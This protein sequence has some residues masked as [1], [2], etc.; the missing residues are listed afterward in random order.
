[1]RVLVTG[2]AGVIGSAVAAALSEAATRPTEPTPLDRPVPLGWFAMVVVVGTAILVGT[3]GHRLS[4]RPG[5]A[6]GGGDGQG[7][8]RR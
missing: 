5:V 4:T 1:M 8:G 7:H 3:I 2:A 6:R